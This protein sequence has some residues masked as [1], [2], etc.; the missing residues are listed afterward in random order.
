MI[1]LLHLTR[2][3]DISLTL[4]RI[5]E[6][7][8]DVPKIAIVGGLGKKRALKKD[9][10]KTGT[11]IFEKLRTPEKVLAGTGITHHALNC[12]N[13]WQDTKGRWMRP[14]LQSA[15]RIR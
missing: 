5:S 11:E 1:T 12:S 14:S 2:R 10:M 13:R 3:E 8:Q 4:G 6:R 9:H 15:W 7:R